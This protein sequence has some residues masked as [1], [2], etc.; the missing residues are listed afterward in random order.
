MRVNINIIGYDGYSFETDDPI[1]FTGNC[2]RDTSKPFGHE[3]ALYCLLT[4]EDPNYYP[5]NIY[6]ETYPEKYEGMF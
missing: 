6:R 1:T 3:M 2:Y 4:I 5:W